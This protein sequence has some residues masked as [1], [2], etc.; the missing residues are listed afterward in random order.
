MEKNKAI[1]LDRDGVINDIVLR[2]GKPGSPRKMDEFV[3]AQGAEKAVRDFKRMGYLTIIFTNQPDIKRGLMKTEDLER[4][5]RFLAEKF[6]L[7]E[8]KTC[9]HDDED[10]C[11]CRKPKPGM[12]LEAASKWSIDLAKSYVIGDNRK[13]IEA[14]KA[15][16]CKTFLIRREYNED[17]KNGFDFEIKNLKEAVLKIREEEKKSI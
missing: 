8:I 4:M 9:P 16:G 14:G 13:D 7:D 6:P 3:L 2:E 11:L 5:H 12:I 17:F 15:A 1:F 10:C